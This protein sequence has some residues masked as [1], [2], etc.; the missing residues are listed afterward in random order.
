MECKP[1]ML[2]AETALMLTLVRGAQLRKAEPAQIFFDSVQCC[3][4]EVVLRSAIERRLE[5]TSSIALS[6]EAAIARDIGTVPQ[7]THILTE[8][9]PGA[10]LVWIAVD[11]PEATVRHRIYE[12]EL[13]LISEFPGVDFDFNIVA[14]LGRSPAEFAT[15]ANLTYTRPA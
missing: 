10:M 2:I 3:D 1:K 13:D 9:V 15:S 7:V 4:Y 5:V 12:K 14:A 6:L 8:R 11:E